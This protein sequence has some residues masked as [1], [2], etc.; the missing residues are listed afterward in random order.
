MLTKGKKYDADKLEL[1]GWNNPNNEDLAGY[2]CWAYFDR[3]GVY[4]GPDADGV[5]PEFEVID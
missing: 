4:L 3:D 1:L 5:E 2:D